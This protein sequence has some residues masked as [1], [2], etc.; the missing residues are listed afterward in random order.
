MTWD[1]QEPSLQERFAPRD[2]CFGCGQAN[3]LG[4]R[5]RSFPADGDPEQL[6]CEW[7]PQDHHV[8]F[9]RVLSGG[10]IGALFDCHCN[11]AAAW[12]LMRR[13]GGKTPAWT[14]TASFT[15]DLARPTPL[16]EPVQLTARAVSSQRYRV[17]VE[18]TLS[19]GGTQTA[20]SHGTFIA[21]KPDHPAHRRW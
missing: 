4:L 6:V 21:V 19:S 9:D 5:I 18:A 11:W 20:T 2:R 8:A 3:D 7:T 15:V 10:V 16:D 12:H 13:D 1:P 17:E 14:V